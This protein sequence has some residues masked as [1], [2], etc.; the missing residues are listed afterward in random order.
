[1]CTRGREDVPSNLRS[2]L[3]TPHGRANDE[4]GFDKSEFTLMNSP[5]RSKEEQGD[6]FPI[7]NHIGN[8][9]ESY[10]H[11]KRFSSKCLSFP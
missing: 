5:V 4:C 6:I 11:G 3:R 2:D 1:M 7:G 9:N 8:Q 10:L